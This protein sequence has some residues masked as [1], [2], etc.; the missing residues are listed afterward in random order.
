[1]MDVSAKGG[2]FVRLRKW[3]IW[4]NTVKLFTF[5]AVILEWDPGAAVVDAFVDRQ[6]VRTQMAEL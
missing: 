5:T 3:L 4:T 1:M 6:A 2:L